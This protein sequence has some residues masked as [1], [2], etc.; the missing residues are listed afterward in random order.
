MTW[1][2]A[3][4]LLLRQQHDAISEKQECRHKYMPRKR[5]EEQICSINSKTNYGCY[6]VPLRHFS[7][8]STMTTSLFIYIYNYIHIHILSILSIQKGKK[9]RLII[10]RRHWGSLQCIQGQSLPFRTWKEEELSQGGRM[11]HILILSGQW[12]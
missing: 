1:E 10:P 9:Q 11:L 6:S 4:D 2:N 5:Q 8:I 3:H 7:K 12:G